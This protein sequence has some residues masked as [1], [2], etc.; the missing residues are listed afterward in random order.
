MDFKHFLVDFSGRETVFGT[1]L[2]ERSQELV[3]LGGFL[4]HPYDI[5]GGGLLLFWR[6][7]EDHFAFLPI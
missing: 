6:A 7:L 3:G 1:S 5:V 4:V 2:A